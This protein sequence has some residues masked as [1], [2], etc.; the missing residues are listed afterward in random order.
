M[1]YL[2]RGKANL[3]LLVDTPTN[4]KNDPQK[5]RIKALSPIRKFIKNEK[6]A[7]NEWKVEKKLT[8][9]FSSLTQIK[10]R[11]HKTNQQKGCFHSESSFLQFVKNFYIL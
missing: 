2:E 3:N 1:N 6:R 10:I 4:Q 11:K 8:N 5:Q 9:Q 7:K